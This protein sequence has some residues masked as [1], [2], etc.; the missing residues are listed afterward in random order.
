MRGHETVAY[1]LRSRPELVWLWRRGRALR[2]LPPYAA[3]RLLKTTL[4]PQEHAFDPRKHRRP[5]YLSRRAMFQGLPGLADVIM[6]GDYITEIGAWQELF[7]D[8]LHSQPRDLG[9]TRLTEYSI[10]W[11]RLQYDSQRQF[12]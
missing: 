1:I 3:L 10:G 5:Y 6:L 11:T 12:S 9:A 7:P 2:E 4:F 8:N